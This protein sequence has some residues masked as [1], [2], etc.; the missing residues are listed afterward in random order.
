LGAYWTITNIYGMEVLVV[1]SVT[2]A[3]LSVGFLALLVRQNRLAA[4]LRLFM[5]SGA[6]ADLEQLLVSNQ[7]SLGQSRDRIE[8][9][10]AW[11]DS[12]DALVAGHLLGLGMVRFQA[13][14]DTGSDLSFALALINGAGDGVVMSSLYGREESRSYAKPVSGGNSSYHLTEE[15][16]AAIQ[17]AWEQHPRGRGNAVGSTPGGP[18]E[19]KGQA[20]RKIAPLG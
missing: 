7:N 9:L 3:V 8:R 17:K 5:G 18:R 15:E 4:R 14:S 20:G 12:L 2:A 11:A 10:E 6:P 1:L 13:F 16:R 19:K